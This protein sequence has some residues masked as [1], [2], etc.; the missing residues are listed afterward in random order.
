MGL[1]RTLILFTAFLID[2][3]EYFVGK[4]GNKTVFTL[5]F[6]QAYSVSSLL[7]ASWVLVTE[8]PGTN[9]PS[10]P[11]PRYTN[12]SIRWYRR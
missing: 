3:G 12:T 5:H 7:A 11:V 10:S 1:K 6:M 2:K 9:N 4:Q 8:A